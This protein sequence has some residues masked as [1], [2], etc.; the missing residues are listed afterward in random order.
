MSKK[1]FI[2]ILALFGLMLFS[3]SPVM[4]DNCNFIFDP[5]DLKQDMGP[6]LKITVSNDNLP[7]GDNKYYMGLAGPNGAFNLKTSLT[8]SD[9]KTTVK[10]DRPGYSS[11]WRPKDYEVTFGPAS[12]QGTTTRTCK[13]KFTVKEIAAQSACKISITSVPPIDPDNPNSIRVEEIVDGDYQ[14]VIYNQKGDEFRRFQTYMDNT[15]GGNNFTIG[16][17]PSGQYAVTVRKDDGP[18]SQ[19]QCSPTTLTVNTRVAT[20][21][22]PAG[23]PDTDTDSPGIAGGD[24]CTAN[25]P[26]GRG[27]AFKTAI[28]CVHT[29]PA[30]FVKD[31]MKFVIGIGGGLAFLMMLL[32]AF[33]MLTSAGNPETLK[34][35]QDRLTSAVI[36]LL[37]V[38]FS[39]LLLQIIGV[40][41]L[42]IPGFKP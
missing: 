20:P 32:G 40:G 36:G 24:S 2:N 4:A 41:I 21:G 38:I 34:A 23:P 11:L 22:N 42:N 15:S 39:I 26:D 25:P 30:E 37:F 14:I 9:G 3:T 5:P 27:P 19:L 29:N 28:G 10:F 1:V 31:L 6:T 18:L 33:Q 8:L 7:G 16:L 13:Q 12:E 35:G 17:F